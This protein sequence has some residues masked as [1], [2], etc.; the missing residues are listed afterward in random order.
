MHK[1]CEVCKEDQYRKKV[2]A[3]HGKKVIC[4]SCGQSYY[5]DLSGNAKPK[6][7]DRNINRISINDALTAQAVRDIQKIATVEVS[8]TA[9][10]RAAVINQRAMLQAQQTNRAIVAK[11]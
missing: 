9:I 4:M 6:K 5:F 10:I 7:E 3:K 11:E 2:W 8:I 1:H